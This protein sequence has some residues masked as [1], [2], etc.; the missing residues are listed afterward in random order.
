MNMTVWTQV[1]NNAFNYNFKKVLI[2]IKISNYNNYNISIQC[3]P[4]TIIAIHHITKAL[5]SATSTP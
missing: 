4:I 1:L 5:S 2:K 3:I